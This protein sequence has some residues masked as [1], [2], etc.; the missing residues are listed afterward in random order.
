M[1]VRYWVIMAI[2]CVILVFLLTGLPHYQVL[3]YDSFT[4]M[5]DGS[6]KHKRVSKGWGLGFGRRPTLDEIHER[7]ERK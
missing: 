6:W 5:E 3:T 1:T 7:S 2:I 4:K